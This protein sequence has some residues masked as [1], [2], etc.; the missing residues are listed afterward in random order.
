MDISANGGRVRPTRDIGG[1]TMDLNGVEKIQVNAAGGADNIT[2]NDLTRTGVTQVAIDLS[3]PS[4]SGQGDGAADSVTVNGTAGRDSISVATIGASVV[5]NGLSAQVTIAGTEG[6]NDSLVVSRGAGDDTINASA[7]NAGQVKLTI[8]GG[9]GDDIITASK[10]DDVV[11][12]GQGSDK[13][14]LGAGN[15]TFVWNPG[16]GSDMVDG[17]AG[18]DTLQSKG[19]NVAEN[20][21]I[22]ANAGHA[23]LVRDIATITMDLDN[24]ETINVQALGGADKITVNDL[25]GTDVNKVNIDLGGSSGGGDGSDDTIVINATSG[26]DVITVT[27][28]NDVITVSGLR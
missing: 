17:Q 16:N 23:R 7:L 24:V 22:S 27:N 4:G 8:N 14:L 28:N 15:D 3:G 13:A 20:I 18:N 25:T 21:D 6:A 19:A 12:G 5:V 9:A 11:I 10:G 2:I 1:V 26:D